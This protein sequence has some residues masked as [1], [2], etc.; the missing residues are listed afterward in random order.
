VETQGHWNDL[1]IERST[2]VLFGL[3][4]LTCLFAHALQPAGKVAF[5]QTAWYTKT[6]AT[7]REVLATVRRARTWWG[8]FNFGTSTGEADVFL[9]PRALLD[10][11]ALA[12]CY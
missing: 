9:I 11:L 3:Y 7:F 4:S 8:Y 2:P 12:A 10:R 1:A 6:E 5:Y